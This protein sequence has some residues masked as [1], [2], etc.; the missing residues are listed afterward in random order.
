M[1]F[2]DLQAL[3]INDERLCGC[4]SDPDAVR[5]ALIQGESDLEVARSGDDQGRIVRALGIRRQ[6]GNGGLIASTE[7]ALEAIRRSIDDAPP[8]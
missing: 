4:A 2:P 8:R 1:T 6:S 5:A 3:T 7:E